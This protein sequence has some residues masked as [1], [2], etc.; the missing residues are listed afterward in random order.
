MTGVIGT[1]G[2]TALMQVGRRFGRE[3]MNRLTQGEMFE[4]VLTKNEIRRLGK[5][6]ARRP[7]MNL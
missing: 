1:V 2:R 6:L 7:F 4:D 3:A 5:D